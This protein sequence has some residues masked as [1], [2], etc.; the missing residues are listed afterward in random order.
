MTARP[1]AVW[2]PRADHVELVLGGRDGIAETT[3]PLVRDDAGWFAPSAAELAPALDVARRPDGEVDYGFRL[4]DDP[5]VVPDPRGRRLPRGVHDRSRTVDA[6]AFTW[7]DRAWGGR[8]LAGAVL[9]ELHPGTFSTEGTLDGAIG[10]LDHLV[11]LGVTAVELMPVA[12]FNGEHGWGYDGVAWYAVHEPYG[13]PDA[14]RRFVDA[15]HA[16]GLAVVQDVVYNHFGPSG[17]Y[18]GLLGPYLLEG[19]NTGWGDAVNL[20]GPDS[21]EV[22]R[23]ILDNAAMWFEEYHVDGLRLDAVHALR[24]ERALPIL[25]E[26]ARETAARSTRLGRPLTLVAESDLNDPRTVRPFA[27]G[28]LGMDGQWSDDFHHAVHVALTGE[29]DGYYADFASLESLAKVW[30]GGFFHD[31]THSSFRGRD[32]G[33]PLPEETPAWRLVVC[34][35]N[36]DQVGNRARGDRLGTSLTREQLEVGAALLLLSPFTP[37][38]FQGEEWGATTPFAFFTAHPEPELGQAVTDGRLREFERMGWDR[39]SVPDPQAPATFEASKLDWSWRDDDEGVGRAI[40]HTYASLTALRR[41]LP[42]LT[43]PRLHDPACEVVA[44]N[45]ARV[46]TV[47]R[48]GVLFAANLG[49]AEADVPS[50]SVVSGPT[51]MRWSTRRVVVSPAG[52]RLPPWSAAV[53]VED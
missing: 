33:R 50:T 9:Y 15:C 22:R 16:R 26:L 40:V 27:D 14:Y 47:R 34:V 53:L 45:A 52:L 21:D 38:L 44:D 49:E 20:D 29:T 32:H 1:F 5:L 19:S 35:Q 41:E 23:F 7:T 31:G 11:E 13:G 51:A 12:A 42:A 39:A 8:Q 24:D 28:G 6:R 43:D 17:N 48:G 37:M 3:L 30:R 4:G 46:F 18:L 36:H 10:H 2:A 25:E